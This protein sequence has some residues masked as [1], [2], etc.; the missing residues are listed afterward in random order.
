MTRYMIVE[1][2]KLFKEG[3]KEYNGGQAAATGAGDK[4]LPKM[5]KWHRRT[6][7]HRED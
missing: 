5:L 3:V 6:R 4:P 2:G 1:R 7:V